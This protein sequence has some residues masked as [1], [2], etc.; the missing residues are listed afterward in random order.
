MAENYSLSI[1]LEGY[2]KFIDQ[3][4]AVDDIIDT[5]ATSLDGL[6]GKFN[7]LDLTNFKFDTKSLE[8]LTTLD[9]K[10]KSQS[11]AAIAKQYGELGKSLQGIE[12]NKLS[13]LNKALGAGARKGTIEGKAEAIGKLTTELKKLTA[14]NLVS[15]PSVMRD[16][17]ASLSV[18]TG[19][20]SEKLSAVQ[21]AIGA[22]AKS[23]GKLNDVKINTDTVKNLNLL[24]LALNDIA[25]DSSIS[26]LG[27][28]APKI[29]ELATAFQLFGK[30]SKT[31]DAK[32]LAI[33]IGA[34]VDALTKFVNIAKTFGGG[35][36][37]KTTENFS[38]MSNA[39][40][41][42]AKAFVEF[43][44]PTKGFDDAEKNIQSVLTALKN[45]KTEFASFSGGT[46][47]TVKEA[48]ESFRAIGEAAT[49]LGARTKS[50]E[51]LPDNINKLNQALL[52]LNV[53]RLE[54]IAPTLNKVAP[55]L[56]SMANLASVT[57][58]SFT[59]L[60]TDVKNS[61]SGFNIFANAVK[62][63]FSVI[64]GVT[65]GLINV[66]KILSPAIFSVGKGFLALPFNAVILSFKTLVSV[67]LAPIKF[68]EALGKATLAFAR[69]LRL[70]EIGLNTLLI[71]FKAIQALLSTLSTAFNA[72]VSV[73]QKV[74]GF[75][76]RF[77]TSSNKVKQEMEVFGNSTDSAKNKA[78]NLGATL[79][80]L[81]DKA[82]PVA[83]SF[84]Q[85]GQ[86]IDSS[87]DDSD[88]AKFV[89]F[90]SS[91]QAIT[92]IG[93]AVTNVL[94]NLSNGMQ[95]F[96]G[97]GYQAAASIE[98][99]GRSLNV[100]SAGDLMRQQTNGAL[101][102]DAAMKATEQTA[103]DLLDRYQLLAYQSIFSRE[104]LTDAQQ[105]AQSLG[106]SS[107]EAESLVRLTADWAAANG[108]SG[109]SIK[110]LIL[111][112]GQMRSLTKAN[113][114]D[115]KQLITAGNVPAFELLRNE[116]ERVTGQQVEMSEVQ[117]LLSAGMIDSD[118]AL[119]A[120][121]AGFKVFE[122]TAVKST[123]TLS[124]L[125]NAFGDA[126]ENI[127][128]GFLTPLLSSEEGLRDFFSNI[129]S[130]ENIIGMTNAA[131]QF[132]RVFAVNVVAV[133]NKATAV[134]R[135]LMA[136][137]LAI[138]EPIRDSITFGLKFA[139]TTAAIASG[140]FVVTAAIS[141]LV[142][143]FSL[144]IGAVPLA[145]AAIAAFI[146]TAI[147]NFDLV[148]NSISQVLYSFSE[149]RGIILSVGKALQQVFNTGSFDV[150]TFSG[151]S[152]LSQSLATGLTY[153]LSEVGSALSSTFNLVVGWMSRFGDLAV[154][155]YGFGVDTIL[156]FAN[157][158][159]AGAGA[160]VSAFQ[161]IAGLFVSWFQPNS[162]P[163]VAPDIDT[164]GV[165]TIATWVG[166]LIKGAQQYIPNLTNIV[167]PLLEKALQI[168]GGI[169]LFSINVL[170]TT[171]TTLTTVLSGL[172]E[173]MVGIGGAIVSEV[174]L[175]ISTAIKIIETLIN[176]ALTFKDKFILTL[177]EIGNFVTG[178]FANI[179]FLLTNSVNGITTILG[180]LIQFVEGI[181][182]SGL[183]GLRYAFPETFGTI[184]ADI[185][186]FVQE[187]AAT[188]SSFVNNTSDSFVDLLV[189][190]SEYG[191]GLITAFADGIIASVNVVADALSAL[192]NM[193]TYW[194]QPNSPPNLLPDIDD[195]GTATA[196]EYL[197]GFTEAD[198]NVINDFGKTIGD[199]LGKLNISG[200]NVEEV[201]RAFA[202][203][204][205]NVNSGDDFG[206]DVME[207]IVS[208]TSDAGPEVQSLISKYKVLAEEQSKLN[209]TTEAYN[210]ELKQA[211]GTLDNI[212]ANEE[213]S[214][215]QKRIDSLQNALTNTY[216]TTEER[217]K[218]QT[219]IDKLQATNKVKQL[220]QQKDAQ[221][222]SVK[223]VQDS[224]NLQKQLLKISDE[225][226][227][228]KQASAVNRVGEAAAKT[229]KNVEERMTKLMLQ[230]RL[231]GKTTEEQIAVYKE[232]LS[233]LEEGSEEYVK[234]QTKII[235]LEAKLEKEREA[236][237]KKAEKR[238]GKEAQLAA[239]FGDAIASGGN[240]FAQLSSNIAKETEKI[241]DSI[242]G[243]VSKVRTTW[244]TFLASF[245]FSR[246]SE[247]NVP[248][249][250]SSLQNA[251]TSLGG[252]FGKI[253]KAIDTVVEYF[254]I[255]VVK[256]KLV[257]NAL[258][259]LATI[260]VAGGIALKIRGIAIAVGTLLTPFNLAVTAITLLAS[261]IYTFVQQSGGFTATITRIQN[262]WKGL[263]QAFAGSAST[264]QA[265]LDFSSFEGIASSIGSL[266]GS[267][268]GKVRQ[269]FNDFYNSLSTAWQNAVTTLQT[270]ITNTW[271]N[272]TSLFSGL[273]IDLSGLQGIKD[274]F[275]KNWLEIMSGI[276]DL[277]IGIT[278][279]RWLLIVR[280]IALVLKNFT[281]PTDILTEV[282]LNFV[283]S[284]DNYIIKPVA[285]AF[286]ENSTILGKLTGALTNFYYGV[287]QVISTSVQGAFKRF[288]SGKFLENLNAFFDN[289]A[290]G[291]AL[292]R[293]LNEAIGNIVP[294]LDANFDLSDFIVNIVTQF[295]Q[296]VDAVRNFFAQVQQI[297]TTG[298]LS[299][300]LNA[301]KDAFA[302]FI[303][304]ISSPAFIAALN[305][306]GKTLGIVAGAV[307]AIGAAI[308]DAAL[309]G[310]LRN[311]ADLFI[312]V[313]QGLDRVFAGFNQIISGNILS[314]VSEVF[315]G[316]FDIVNGVF[317]TIGQVI[318]DTVL[319]MVEFFSPTWAAKLEPVVSMVGRLV[320]GFIG[321]QATSA[322][323][324]SAIGGFFAKL[325][326][327][328][329]KT[330][331][332]TRST[333]SVFSSFQKILE[334]AK[335]PFTN[336]INAFKAAGAS[337]LKFSESVPYLRGTLQAL[338]NVFNVLTKPV[339]FLIIGLK[340][341]VTSFLPASTGT[342]TLTKVMQVLRNVTAFLGET[343]S[344]LVGFGKSLW[345]MFLEMIPSIVNFVTTVGRGVA[346][347]LRF[348]D[349][350][351]GFVANATP[352]R[353]IL[354]WLSELF[355]AIGGLLR[356][357][358]Q[359]LLS[360]G[361]NFINL[362]TNT[363]SALKPLETA[364]GIFATLSA[365]ASSFGAILK[366]VS[367][368]FTAFGITVY[369]AVTNGIEQ[370]L[371]IDYVQRFIT[372]ATGWVD[373]IWTGLATFVT[374]LPERIQSWTTALTEWLAPQSPPKF[375][376]DLAQWGI[377]IALVL[378]QAMVD[379]PLDLLLTLGTNI[380]RAI[381]DFDY[382]Q[383]ATEL[384]GK[385][386][387]LLS[388]AITGMEKVSAKVSDIITFDEAEL[389][390]ASGHFTKFK[391]ALL[392]F[393]DLTAVPSAFTTSLEAIIGFFKGEVTFPETIR[394]VVAEL[395]KVIKFT[396]IPEIFINGINTIIGL[397]N[398]NATLSTIV[399]GVVSALQQFA[400]LIGI[401]ESVITSIS[402][403]F[404]FL[405]GSDVDPATANAV[406][407]TLK[408][409]GMLKGIP[410]SVKTSLET[411]FGF[412]SENTTVTT[413]I[414]A[415]ALAL[416]KF[417][418]LT[419]IGTGFA[420][421]FKAVF[422]LFSG[423]AT[424]PQTVDRVS[425]ALE[426]IVTTLNTTL[427][428]PFAA[429]DLTSFSTA[430]TSIKTVLE[431]IYTAFTNLTTVDLSGI[432]SAFEPLTSL[433][434]TVGQQIE[435][436]KAGLS[437]IPG[438]NLVGA[439]V[440]GTET[441]TTD[442]ETSLQNAVNNKDI[443]LDTRISIITDQTNLSEQSANVLTAFTDSL[444]TNAG[445]ADDNLTETINTFVASGFKPEDIRALANEAGVEVPAGFEEAF[446]QSENWA[447]VNT[448]AG[449]QL[450]NVFGEIKAKLGIQSPSTVARDQIGLPIIQGI[451]EGLALTSGVDFKTPVGAAMTAILTA[452][453]QK[454]TE[455]AS[456]INLA[457][458]IFT[459]DAAVL[460]V[461]RNNINEFVNVFTIGFE[462]VTT[463]LE[464]ALEVWNTM[465][466]EF[467]E[468][469]L[470]MANEFVSAFVA[471]FQELIEQVTDKL[472]SLIATIR[473]MKS[474]FVSAGRE[475][476]VGLIDGIK[477]YLQDSGLDA[478]EG[479][480]KG[481]ASSI[482]SD[483]GILQEFYNSGEK[484]G[485]PFVEGIAKGIDGNRNNST[486]RSAI[487]TLVDRIIQIAQERA[488][489][490]SP[491]KVAA[492]QIG[493]PI[494]QGIGVGLL[495][496]VTFVDDA[497]TNLMD[498][499]K[500]QNTN[501]G[502]N[503]T[504]GVAEGIIG[505]ANIVTTAV[506]DLANRGIVAARTA[507][508]IHSPSKV[509]ERLI[510]LPFVQG[511]ARALENGK[512]MLTP[513][514]SD[515]LSVLP[516]NTDFTFDIG[517]NF[518]QMRLKEQSIDVRYNGLINSLPTLSQDINL[519]RAQMNNL[520]ALTMQHNMSSFVN[521]RT[522]S[523]IQG[524]NK[525]YVN[526]A[527]HIAVMAREQQKR[528]GEQVSAI[529][530]PHHTNKQQVL[531][532]TSYMNDNRSTV[533]NN[534][535]EFHMHI[536][537]SDAK[538]AR[539][540]Q[541]NFNSMRYGY[542]FR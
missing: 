149:I 290:I 188:F 289:S 523:F 333:S 279:G 11:L 420:E 435:N 355:S 305:T 18:T 507:L 80:T 203:G 266:L 505:S 34:T 180:G 425:T 269:K 29:K 106:F 449:N 246:N 314:G 364:K 164:Y 77:G 515:L 108:L 112:L 115:M 416:G 111:P 330:Q 441:V 356:V 92:T 396:A 42:L 406:A 104:Q 259:S 85:M 434:D 209:R 537:T 440:E 102:L 63:S 532:N 59:R 312:V 169:G 354:T 531:A 204:L 67:V 511:I 483:A 257:S 494:T 283:N 40:K 10:G 373:A 114:V 58:K 317:E 159:W 78:S 535:N 6:A 366:R 76:D 171:I 142:S 430:I 324:F 444:K 228:S 178:T 452:A 118:T 374:S 37:N 19:F 479:A 16:L 132:G 239:E 165:E 223:S 238:L 82:L 528:L 390:A 157:G 33:N 162:P 308:V 46:T 418:S 464:D 199:T 271:N 20:D 357:T 352:V 481:F 35:V 189:S 306:I 28:L 12:P 260:L 27:E 50:F 241:N 375:L 101:D 436:I 493:V 213:I 512:G 326:P 208:L 296:A 318:A 179:G 499:I 210:N 95:Q 224:I 484:F 244:A 302:E 83:N 463:L 254:D 347:V 220:E 272:F 525:A 134:F 299:N 419:G 148:K 370:L 327:W 389:S 121:I 454:L 489:I 446:N 214:A 433:F 393:A 52:N 376:P 175:A 3:A 64:S 379:A 15:L 506:T 268:I 53:K 185:V 124:G 349:S 126:K 334:A 90:S 21:V 541:K 187:S 303:S 30:D 401:P 133:V 345:N 443:A 226:D 172:F 235:E 194:L 51:R 216:L 458:A 136:V 13:D 411:I 79:D 212:N 270:N 258:I 362:A 504:E 386:G 346:T 94:R 524:M 116:L 237:S 282:L 359:L 152:T 319:A 300:L 65:S 298:P 275:S 156:S 400:T 472:R 451:A 369:N 150:D 123:G 448:A 227:G 256:N 135:T 145:T 371:Q 97:T 490:E 217:T 55:A 496:G 47:K 335:T 8:K 395:S 428:N 476:A 182:L 144:F 240:P 403:I 394:T 486:L 129:L 141:T 153:G 508:G 181:F 170:I 109:E 521:N 107:V 293:N 456:S 542:R 7:K 341:L 387:G 462:T 130:A 459:L 377:D 125:L 429:L 25:S 445:I 510:G 70:L 530:V 421:S 307:L 71:P 423:E 66:F 360:I 252:I 60:N 1:E 342:S 119:R 276:A 222:D 192:G 322:K 297:F 278:L 122:G 264:G 89:R 75:F 337:L 234:T 225:F 470:D 382:A 471:A 105:L 467:F 500:L 518:E 232:Y 520:K 410:D 328:F 93:G 534:H 503:F 72:F 414:D 261:A 517:S 2:Q 193:I 262:A 287:I 447:G 196:Q 432:S 381:V 409:F 100:L 249:N 437:I 340:N 457:A 480:V 372:W 14:V 166:G 253:A 9:L 351:I 143:G 482:G 202:T 398:S 81:D 477:N 392:G 281:L 315:G 263:T 397:F 516:N 255:Y 336:I 492:A 529:A 350:F 422:D 385:I 73:I 158:V 113:T 301:N 233:T 215:N 110:S 24:S 229:A 265:T 191:Y 61:S 514:T 316:I 173:I 348:V 198:L 22:L 323:V 218:I 41:E 461:T 201:T 5:V 343:F 468:T 384:G 177:N 219:Q 417:N 427:G 174:A 160:I 274:F 380:G 466:E 388:S 413:T 4:G 331:G 412:F 353:V 131:T 39:V 36:F 285:E 539:R 277:I 332:A 147:T 407:Q 146:T 284:I 45:L 311:L 439:E 538:A 117:D 320:A 487:N 128:R 478:I 207:Q 195:W 367:S 291:Q 536:S 23:M 205:A 338:L 74:V 292:E 32:N 402:G 329:T 533:V 325:L 405:S 495:Q 38:A 103:Q 288:G 485:K 344:K 56:Q 273:K 88:T 98:N 230:Q 399:Q 469:L 460:E 168:F 519:N 267:V 84:K 361:K 43:K 161:Q 54:E 378:L 183:I 540:M 96:L 176:P 426:N 304:E 211:Q 527:P 497:I 365:L 120:V 155:M 498:S 310:I 294:S 139:A 48:A 57:G 231:A 251:A 363:W 137:W 248:I 488:D 190:V 243:M 250:F 295:N 138:P 501:I 415:V 522:Q 31:F 221:Q 68:L 474:E 44:T 62:T 87:I 206:A 186:T 442:V 99:V 140:I 473:A 247:I 69:E 167:G 424:F 280:G 368:I 383:F 236:A 339:Q 154:Q 475:L 491:S 453:Q 431:D 502:M 184:Y 17:F 200:V 309:I 450:L 91:L 404:S 313:G 151:L 86:S 408:Q 526:V 438:I 242:S 391:D 163:K 286:G 49:S 455:I 245:T 358:G 127:V 465:F 509:T 513:L 26:K 321:W 197:N